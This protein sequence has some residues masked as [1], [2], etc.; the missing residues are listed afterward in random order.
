MDP[1]LVST[2]VGAGG[3]LLGTATNAFFQ[4][5]QNRAQRKWASNEQSKQ[6]TRNIEFWNMQ[7]EY[8]SP[9]QVMQR[10]KQAGLNSHFGLLGNQPTAAGPI[11]PVDTATGQFDAPDVG[12]GVS[13]AAEK[14]ANYQLM[15]RQKLENDGIRIQNETA[16]Q[17]LFR[18]TFD[19]Q[20]RGIDFANYEKTK[21]YQLDAAK[22]DIDLKRANTSYTLNQKELNSVKNQ[23]DLLVAASQIALNRAN[24]GQSNA[25]VNKI[26]QEIKNLQ[27]DEKIKN[28]QRQ[29]SELGVQPNSPT[30]IYMLGTVV[31]H[32]LGDY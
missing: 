21:G 16:T 28:L 4:G 25:N 13:R 9:Q 27:V 5:L 22:A 30:W 8:N 26:Q 14:I 3:N 31:K 18:K 20:I 24:T 32:L 29:M 2:L 10:N 11:A 19:A 23:S 6:Y 15:E 1:S 17:D 12:S 7:N